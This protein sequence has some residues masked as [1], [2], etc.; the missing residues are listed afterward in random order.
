M[1]LQIAAASAASFLPRAPVIRYG[2]TNLGA[3]RRTVWPE[4]W[5][6]R[7]QW[8]APE[9]APMPITQGGSDAISPWSLSRG[10]AGRTNSALPASFTPWTAKTFLAR[11]I[12]TVRIA[13]DFPFRKS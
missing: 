4:A 10:R 8:W 12:P 3:I 9:Q 11:S 5:N 13:M 1:A 6:S 7:A 2:V